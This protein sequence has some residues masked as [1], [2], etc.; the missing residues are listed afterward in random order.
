MVSL[1]SVLPCLT[2]SSLSCLLSLLVSH[3]CIFLSLKLQNGKSLN[4]SL[5]NQAAF[6]LKEY[7]ISRVHLCIRKLYTRSH[8][9]QALYFIKI[10]RYK[11]Y[12][13]YL[14]L[15]NIDVN[16]SL[17]ARNKQS[18]CE[19]DL[20]YLFLSNFTW[21]YM[22]LF[23]NRFCCRFRFGLSMNAAGLILIIL[24]LSLRALKITD[25]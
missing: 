13:L 16:Q 18:C 25:V 6:L 11:Q 21:I 17:Y 10:A 8:L 3:E 4:Q 14:N 1:Y 22:T 2:S 9:R 15:F 12:S 19:W 7:S 20:L 5:R 23:R 24:V